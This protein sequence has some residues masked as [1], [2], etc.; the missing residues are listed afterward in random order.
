MRTPWTMNTS[1]SLVFFGLVLL[2]AGAGTYV[3]VLG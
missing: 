1:E 3:S 2:L